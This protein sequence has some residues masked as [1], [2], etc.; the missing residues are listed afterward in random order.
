[1]NITF[2]D[3]EYRRVMLLTLLGEWMINA[4]LKDPDPAMEDTASKVYAQAKDTPMAELVAFNADLLSWAPTEEFESEAHAMID[5]YDDKTF[6]EE[7]TARMIERDLIDQHGE[8]TVSS[9]R[10]EQ[11]EREASSI[12]KAYTQEFEERGIERLR[13]TD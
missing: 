10:P 7:L 9:M 6:W 8:R 1:M 3:E 4:I 11:R 12:G 13:V 5:Q 2:S